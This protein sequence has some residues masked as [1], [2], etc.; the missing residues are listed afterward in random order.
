MVIGAAITLLAPLFVLA[1][2]LIKVRTLAR[3]EPVPQLSGQPAAAGLMAEPA[4][5]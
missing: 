3:P 1:G 4:R 2:P 5:A